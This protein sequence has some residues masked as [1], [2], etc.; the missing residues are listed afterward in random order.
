MASA[1]T[2][3]MGVPTWHRFAAGLVWT[4]TRRRWSRR[5]STGESG[6]LRVRA[7]VGSDERGRRRSAPGCR[8]RCGWPMRRGRRGSGWR[9][10]STA[11]GV[12]CVVAAP[13]KIER[14][15]QD[16]VKTDRRDAE[17]LVRLLMVGELHPVRVPATE[18][19]GAARSRPRARGRPRRSDARAAPVG[20][21]LLRHDVRFDG[22]RLDAARTA[23][24]WPRSSSAERG[25]AGR[26]STTTSARSTRCSSAAT[27]LE[28]QTI[29]ELVPDS[30]WADDGRAAALPARH[31]HAL[32]GR[33]VRRDRR[34]RRASRG[35]GQL[36]SYL[37]LVPSEHNS[38]GEH[39]PAQGP[40]TKSGIRHA[41]PAAGRGGLALP[42][43][44]RPRA[45]ELAR[46]QAGQPAHVTRDLL[47]GPTAPAPHLAAPR[48]RARQAPHHRRGRR[49]PRARRLLLGDH[50]RRLNPA[51]STTSVK[52]A[53]GRPGPHA[54]AHPR[55]SYEQPP[56][57]HARS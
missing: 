25:R 12:G 20:K 6:E 26:R 36:M 28:R 5:R 22:Q 13:G 23:S 47:A 30:P 57:G 52:E 27:A 14:P 53:A 7:V 11:A 9:G 40:I 54:R 45:R 35:A 41:P 43:P 44:R 2:A 55:F 4:C 50:Q 1:P 19:G 21:L 46:R 37:G 17:R 48:R 34:L 29:G 10:R 3:I 56:R 51:D 15:P 32:G 24:G 8:G 42:P 31:R 33:A 38:T 49:R 39:A 16:R 18:R